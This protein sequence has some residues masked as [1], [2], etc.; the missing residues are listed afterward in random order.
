[1]FVGYLIIFFLVVF[2]LRN[3]PGENR[4]VFLP[5]NQCEVIKGVFI[6]AVF[7]AHAHDYVGDYERL[8]IFFKMGSWVRYLFSPILVVPFFFFSGYGVWEN[9]SCKGEAYLKEFPERRIL[10]TLLNFDVAVMVFLLLS[11]TLGKRYSVMWILSAF[12]GWK[13]IGNSNWYI[14]VILLCYGAAYFSFKAKSLMLLIFSITCIALL[15]SFVKESWWYSNVIAFPAGAVYSNY[16]DDIY[17]WIDGHF[18]LIIFGCLGLLGGLYLWP[19]II[20]SPIVQGNIH[21]VVFCCLLVAIMTK[22]EIHN[23]I[24]SW[25]GKKLF[26]IYIRGLR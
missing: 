11:V 20:D 4:S 2:G 24:L 14:F 22:I 21:A 17:Q 18:V 9:M 6:L 26:P 10:T 1:M 19:R 3:R 25:C 7:M 23:P 16:K 15:L 12:L 8:D 13:S 5:R